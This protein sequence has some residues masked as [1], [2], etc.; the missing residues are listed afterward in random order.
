LGSNLARH[1]DKFLAQPHVV[2]KKSGIKSASGLNLRSSQ[3]MVLTQVNANQTIQDIADVTT[4]D[5]SEVTRILYNLFQMGL[6]EV[7]QEEKKEEN[8][9][10]A[11]FFSNM[12]FVLTKI[13]GPVAP[14]VI[15][16]VL[17][18][19]NIEKSRFPSVR[20]A[21]LIE[22]ISDEINDDQKKISFQAKMLGFIKQ[23]LI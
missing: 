17:Q 4:I 20:V 10:G 1:S 12:E 14:F 3:W 19:L 9:L 13:I 7:H 23:E 15:D 2:Y 5:V 11:K 8:I 21:E 16:D 18:D 6:I 22:L